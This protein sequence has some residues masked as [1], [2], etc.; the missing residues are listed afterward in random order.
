MQRALH[1]RPRILECD[2]PCKKKAENTTDE[3]MQSEFVVIP[4]C[5]KYRR[6]TGKLK[7]LIFPTV[8]LSLC[9]SFSIFYLFIFLPPLGPR[10]KKIPVTSFWMSRR[11]VFQVY[12]QGT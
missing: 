2:Q 9:L 5:Y 12:P 7:G 1:A 6:I 3:I 4:H 10:W 11:K 8:A